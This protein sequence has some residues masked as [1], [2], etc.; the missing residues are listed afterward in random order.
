M[1]FFLV[2]FYQVRLLFSFLLRIKRIFDILRYVKI[3]KVKCLC[4]LFEEM[5][6]GSSLIKSNELV[7]RLRQSKIGCERNNNEKM[8]ILYEL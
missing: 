4:F 3:Q 8:F 1:F 7:E 2:M 6:L 5:F